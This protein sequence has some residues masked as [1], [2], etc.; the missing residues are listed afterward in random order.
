MKKEDVVLRGIQ[1]RLAS[2]DD[3]CT[4][5]QHEYVDEVC[6]EW[7]LPGPGDDC[8]GVNEVTTGLFRIH[9]ELVELV[10]RWDAAQEV[11]PER[12]AFHGKSAQA[13][14]AWRQVEACLR[15]LRQYV[16]AHP[17]LLEELPGLQ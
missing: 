14:F 17:E 2:D 7:K 11:A 6:H 5:E 9:E 3:P 15:R 16:K 1:E 4:V 13:T 8:G 10:V 12:N